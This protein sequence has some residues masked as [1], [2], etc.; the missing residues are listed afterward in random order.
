MLTLLSLGSYSNAQ[1]FKT[2]ENYDAISLK[3]MITVFCPRGQTRLFSCSEE[4][5]N[6]NEMAYFELPEGVIADEVEIIG[7]NGKKEVRQTKGYDNVKKQSDRRYNLWIWTLFQRP[8]LTYGNN[9]LRYIAKKDRRVVSE[10]EFKVNVNDLGIRQC[11]AG[12]Y[13]APF[14]SDCDNGAHMCRQYF[15]DYNYCQ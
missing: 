2:G 4:I 11:P 14:P 5:L 10:G 8:L 15:R 1:R 6:P 13:S 9:T 3:G 12:R 7:H